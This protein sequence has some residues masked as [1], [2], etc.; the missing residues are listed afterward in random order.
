LDIRSL[1]PYLWTASQPLYKIKGHGFVQGLLNGTLSWDS[2][3]F[4]LQQDKQFLNAFNECLG[5]LVSK[6]PSKLRKELQAIL[7]A[8]TDEKDLLSQPSNKYASSTDSLLTFLKSVVREQP[9]RIGLASVLACFLLYNKIGHY[10]KD[11]NAH[12]TYSS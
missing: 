5:V 4:F 6:T 11:N 2:F 1:D 8:G 7:E 3:Q 9:Y 10:L 12:P